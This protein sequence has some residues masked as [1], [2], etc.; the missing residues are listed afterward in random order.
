MS[1]CIE[2]RQFSIALPGVHDERSPQLSLYGFPPLH[3][4]NGDGRL[5][6]V[7]VEAGDS[8]CFDLGRRV[9]R[10]WHLGYLGTAFQVLRDVTHVAADS[11]H[12]GGVC[13]H[14]RA[15]WTR[16]ENYIAHYRKVLQAAMPFEALAQQACPGPS[17]S[18][19]FAPAH[20]ERARSHPHT[21]A[22]RQRCAVSQGEWVTFSAQPL[23]TSEGIADMHWLAG[24]LRQRD[25]VRLVPVLTRA[26][27]LIENLYERTQ[28]YHH[29]AHAAA[30]H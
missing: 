30:G 28:T 15:R 19:G 1:S 8:N 17:L 5:H 11:V 4:W 21:N 24:M 20:L 7:F 14:T 10:R 6:V 22:A 26:D 13:L 29:L 25:Q 2:F 3:D 23:A 9:A 16:P 27:S 18:Y 12:G